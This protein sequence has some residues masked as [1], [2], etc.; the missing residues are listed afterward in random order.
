MSQKLNKSYNDML[1]TVSPAV[2]F[3]ITRRCNLS[4]IY[5]YA[6]EGSGEKDYLDT[7]RIKSIL[8]QFKNCGFQYV[9]VS[10]GEPLLRKDCFHILQ[11]ASSLM[12]VSMIT[13]AH[14]ID[15]DTARDLAGIPRFD[16]RVSLDASDS[17]HNDP[18]R[19]EGSYKKTLTGIKNLLK[20]GM[21]RFI[22]LCMTVTSI[23]IHNVE[24]YIHWAA[25]LGITSVVITPVVSYGRAKVQKEFLVP[26]EKDLIHMFNILYRLKDE[27]SQRLHIFG[28]TKNVFK[29]ALKK[30]SSMIKCPVGQRIAVDFRGRVYPCSLLMDSNFCAGNLCD[31]SLSE[32][33]QSK[34]MESCKKCASE[35]KDILYPCKDC[36]WKNICTAGCLARAYAACGDPYTPDPDCRVFSQLLKELNVIKNNN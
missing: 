25:G 15:F 18:L 20:A 17:L 26:A 1:E 5:C 34:K 11:Y 24:D 29:S 36:Q 27:Y 6:D 9:I 13:N 3:E 35:R 30:P 31:E 33:L 21:R 23:N 10:G 28:S 22:T 12:P 16:I 4:C 19:G 14:L 8:N 2:Y 7:V 32:I